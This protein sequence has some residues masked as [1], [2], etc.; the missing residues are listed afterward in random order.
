VDGRGGHALALSG[1]RVLSS[2]D[3][4]ESWNEETR[5]LPETISGMAFRW[6]AAGADPFADGRFL[7]AGFAS[8]IRPWL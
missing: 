4:G 6:Q 2:A 8:A 1:N 3:G 5:G 7:I